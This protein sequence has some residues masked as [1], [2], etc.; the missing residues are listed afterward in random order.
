MNPDSCCCHAWGM[1]EENA[2]LRCHGTQFIPD[3]TSRAAFEY[4]AKHILFVIVT[5]GAATY[6]VE[7]SQCTWLGKLPADNIYV[8]TDRLP[9]PRPRTPHHWLRAELPAGMRH[10]G[11]TGDFESDFMTK[12]Y[13]H[14]VRKAGQGYNAGWI[15]AQTRFTYG[16]KYAAN[17]AVATNSGSN[18]GNQS[19][20]RSS[21]SSTSSGK[22]IKWI[23]LIDD[24]TIVQLDHLVERVRHIDENQHPWYFSRRGWGGAG[25]LYG[26]K[27]IEILHDRL[28][29]CEHKYFVRQ[30]RASD[31][32]L[33]KCAGHL[34]LRDQMEHTMSHC[35]A[36]TRPENVENPHQVTMHG[37]KDFYPPVLKA[38]WRV[39]LYY[40]AMYCKS[41][42]A[43]KDVVKW[44]A[45]T[46][47]ASCKRATCDK[48]VDQRR[49][50]LWDE[51]SHNNTLRMLPVNDYLGDIHAPTR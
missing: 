32:M 3:C 28:H 19:G 37:K 9:T 43:V 41:P 45:C 14:A 12:G 11:D 21:S 26:K 40:L 23:M 7:V 29:E 13:V 47:G 18:A 49:E 39:S 33:L 22:H 6:R 5:G 42:K 34:K 31:A 50:R 25:H 4:A 48:V 20:S 24:D 35:P 17:V 10:R 44:S 27:A 51:F 36:A 46:Y 30:F 38:T 15:L 2:A 16:L 8:I 1:Y